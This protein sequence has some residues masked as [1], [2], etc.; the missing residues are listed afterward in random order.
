M[1]QLEFFF[2]IFKIKMKLQNENEEINERKVNFAKQAN[3]VPL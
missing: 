1:K 3:S 2:E